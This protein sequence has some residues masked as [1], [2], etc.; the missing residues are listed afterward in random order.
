MLVRRKALCVSR[1]MRVVHGMCDFLLVIYAYFKKLMFH[2]YVRERIST[3]RAQ[4]VWF[5]FFPFRW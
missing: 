2:F 3:A 4:T 5:L 1:A